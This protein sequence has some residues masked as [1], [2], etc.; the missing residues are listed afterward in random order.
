[1][2]DK[3]VRTGHWGQE[4][5]LEFIDFRLLW[6]GRLNR[7]DITTFFRISVPQASL[8]LAKYQELH[9]TTWC[10]IELRRLMLRLQIS[11]LFFQVLT[12]I[13]T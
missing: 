1:M 11:N 6:E 9:Q 5:R 13:I 2:I 12:V 4:R 7:A 10:M 8:D 3:M